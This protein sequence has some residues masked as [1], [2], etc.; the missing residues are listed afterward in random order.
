MCRCET[1]HVFETETLNPRNVRAFMGIWK[2]TLNHLDLEGPQ[3]HV[4]EGTNFGF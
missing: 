2:A 1:Q 4:S 3:S